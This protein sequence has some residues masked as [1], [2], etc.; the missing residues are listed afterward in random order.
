MKRSMPNIAHIKNQARERLERRNAKPNEQPL[1][2]TPK[3]GASRVLIKRTY[4][5]VGDILNHLWLI[6][7]VAEAHRGKK[8]DIAM[9][10][11]LQPYLDFHPL[12]DKVYDHREV[13]ESAYSVIIDTSDVC[14]NFENDNKPFVKKQR[15]EIWA[16]AFGIP[17]DPKK[18]ARGGISGNA[19]NSANARYRLGLLGITGNFVLFQPF[20]MEDS[21]S[22]P[23]ETARSMVEEISR[24]M[25]MP[26]VTVDIKNKLPG[27]S[28]RIGLLEA[29]TWLGLVN[30]ASYV[31]TVD[32]G[33]YHAA[34]LL[35]KPTLCFFAWT[36]PGAVG[37]YYKE[38]VALWRDMNRDG[39]K[40]QYC[41]CWDRGWRC[42]MLPNGNVTMPLPCMSGWKTEDLINGLKRLKAGDFDD[43]QEA[44]SPAVNRDEY[45]KI[46][47]PP[48]IGDAL[49]SLAY[50]QSIKEKTKKKACLVVKGS[51]LNRSGKFLQLFDFVDM[52][53][54]DKFDIHPKNEPKYLTNG[55]YNYLPSGRNVI[56]EADVLV[57]TN[58]LLEQGRRLED[59]LPEYTANLDIG[60][61]NFRFP[62]E[63]LP[64]ARDIADS[65]GEPYC[66]F[67]FGPKGGNT[68]SSH[69]RNSIWKPRDWGA[70]AQKIKD[71]TGIRK[72]LC[73][74]AQYD[75]EYA[76]ECMAC[77]PRDMVVNA[78]GKLSISQTYYVGIRSEFFVSFQSGIGIFLTYLGVPGCMWWRAYGDSRET[79]GFSSFNE[80]MSHC[81]AP[82]WALD[83]RQYMPLI[84]GRQSPQDIV[85]GIKDRGWLENKEWPRYRVMEKTDGN[86]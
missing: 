32:T 26:V 78:V 64:S 6:N 38:T 63:E 66:L 70:L 47:V 67:Y 49:W 27:L 22:L 59:C 25:G 77:M 57:I 1:A 42:R 50:V 9:P 85:S 41:P 28:G 37:K 33:S 75:H 14:V 53:V 2:M 23:V 7:A 74:G 79:D 73:V 3:D 18:H 45:V 19:I 17:F 12:I 48:G 13:R 21:K 34:Q 86:K 61:D 16:E 36:H 82:Q 81:W 80:G 31:V 46:A 54:Y 68:V 11:P 44:S 51:D 56:P 58:G 84:Y 29:K 71:E 76:D 15:A 24:E 40:W 52:V 35:Q 62:Q 83:T 8:I 69:N 43:L 60:L 20:G 65:I 10:K 55:A 30:S 39:E 72:I 5:G 4:G